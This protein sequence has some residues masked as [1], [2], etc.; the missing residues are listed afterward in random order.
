MKK[1]TRIF[2]IYLTGNATNVPIKDVNVKCQC[3]T[4]KPPL[5]RQICVCVS[6]SSSSTYNLAW[7]E[8][9]GKTCGCRHAADQQREEQLEGGHGAAA[10]GESRSH[11]LETHECR[12][13]AVGD[14]TRKGKEEGSS[15]T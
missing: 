8:V 15:P 6:V 4:V 2:S 10:Q 14:M 5:D 11:K 12:K 7:R 3:V 9:A 13:H 1:P